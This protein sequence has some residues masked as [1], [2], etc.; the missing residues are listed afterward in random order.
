MYPDIFYAGGGLG[1][2]RGTN[3]LNSLST[4]PLRLV[5]NLIGILKFNNYDNVSQVNSFLCY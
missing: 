2:L 4:C 1:R 5:C 3:D